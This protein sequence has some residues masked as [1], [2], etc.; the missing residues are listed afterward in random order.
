MNHGAA[1]RFTGSYLMNN[2]RRPYLMSQS[3]A[4]CKLLSASDCHACRFT[5]AAAAF[6]WHSANILN[7][8]GIDS[9]P[10]RREKAYVIKSLFHLPLCSL[11]DDYEIRSLT[12][13]QL[14]SKYSKS[15]CDLC[16]LGWL[17]IPSVQINLFIYANFPVSYWL[18]WFFLP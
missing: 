1:I 12:F 18:L 14:L 8:E 17:Y 5:R 11:K 3:T 16:F 6:G 10:W 15:V 7:K 2:T 13:K 4:A 9:S